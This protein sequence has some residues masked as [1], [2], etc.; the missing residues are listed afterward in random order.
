MER[1][2]VSETYYSVVFRIQA[3]IKNPVLLNIPNTNV[4]KL[5]PENRI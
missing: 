5:V 1:N 4:V 3:D 2:P